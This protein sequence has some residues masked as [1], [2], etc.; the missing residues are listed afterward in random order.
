[1]FEYQ[2][3]DPELRGAVKHYNLVLKVLEAKLNGDL[4]IKRKVAVLIAAVDSLVSVY[5]K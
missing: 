5:G 4:S 1:M 2:S 3:D